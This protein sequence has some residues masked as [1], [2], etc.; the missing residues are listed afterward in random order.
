MNVANVNAHLSNALLSD[1]YESL[2]N[3]NIGPK[4]GSSNTEMNFHFGIYSSDM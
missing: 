1:T 4:Y 3:T 2:N